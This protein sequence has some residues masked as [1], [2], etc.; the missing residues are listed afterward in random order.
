MTS[1]YVTTIMD[2]NCQFHAVIDQLRV[3]NLDSNISHDELRSN[4]VAQLCDNLNT[5]DGSQSLQSFVTTDFSTYLQ[6]MSKNGESGDNI[7]LKA[8]CELYNAQIVVISSNPDFS[9][10]L[11]SS[12][13]QYDPDKPCLILG[14]FEESKGEHYVSLELSASS[15]VN[16]PSTNTW[17]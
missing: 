3:W 7:T 14:H 15:V 12:S 4:V 16:M 1:V 17:V 2:G 11:V 10:Q 13:N 5:S 6:T 9:P 8:V